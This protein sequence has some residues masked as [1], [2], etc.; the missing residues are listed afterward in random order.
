MLNHK[1]AAKRDN[2][3]HTDKTHEQKVMSKVESVTQHLT[4]NVK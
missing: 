1:M 3:E 4:E 2:N